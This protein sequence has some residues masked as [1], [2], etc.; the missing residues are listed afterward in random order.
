MYWNIRGQEI[1]TNNIV[2][3]DL[4]NKL[5]IESDHKKYISETEDEFLF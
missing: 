2:K 4:H 1:E 3:V 5:K